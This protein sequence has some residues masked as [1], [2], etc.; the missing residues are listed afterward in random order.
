MNLNATGQLDDAPRA[1]VLIPTH[2]TRHLALCVASLRHQRTPPWAVVVS[3]DND[4]AAIGSLLREVW[5]QTAA[6]LRERTGHEPPMLHASR[7]TLGQARLNQVRN[8]GLRALI[9]AGHLRDQDVVV[10]CDGD[11][12]LEP[13]AIGKHVALRASGVDVTVCYR[14]ELTE[15][16]TP[17]VLMGDVAGSEASFRAMLARCATGDELATLRERQSRYERAQRRRRWIPA[18]TGLVKA[19]KPKI[20]GGHHSV[21]VHAFKAVNGFDERFG[22]YR[23]NDDD[24]GRRLYALRPRLNVHIAIDEILAVHLWHPIRAPSKLQMAPGFELFRQAWT[25]RAQLGL[26][27]PREQPAVMVRTIPGGAGGSR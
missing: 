19:H 3:C 11:T 14:V 20:L 5:P 6:A 25:C 15:E 10:V 23:F 17:G 27:N 9:N 18:W 26:D 21:A 12:M 16:A 8:N 4:D 13:D 24:L 7:P 22:G 2:T 1:C